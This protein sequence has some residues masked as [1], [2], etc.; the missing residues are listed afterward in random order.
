MVAIALL[1]GSPP[2]SFPTSVSDVYVWVIRDSDVWSAA[3][4]FQGID[5]SRDG[6]HHYLAVDGPIWG[7]GISVDV[8]IGVRTSPTN[9]SLA[10]FRDVLITRSE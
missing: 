8:V 6:A 2:G 9:V 4:S 7:P 10:L 1:N 5:W 3:M